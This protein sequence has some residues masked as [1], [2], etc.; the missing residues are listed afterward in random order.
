VISMAQGSAVLQ[1]AV[2]IC[3]TL[4]HN[5]HE[6]L[7]SSLLPLFGQVQR[8]EIWELQRELIALS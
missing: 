4:I 3:F 5:H 2:L 6:A 7:A 8:K 1:S